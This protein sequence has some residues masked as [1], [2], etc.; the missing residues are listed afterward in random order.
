MEII[1]QKHY[2]KEI[3]KIAEDCI[4][5]RK[6]QVK[7]SLNDIRCNANSLDDII[8]DIVDNHE[9]IT[10]TSYHN[11]VLSFTK[12]LENTQYIDGEDAAFR[13]MYEDVYESVH[14]VLKNG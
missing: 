8:E 10:D 3:K 13:A 5:I 14:E 12:N 4:G 6:G 11:Q 1:T 2:D 9:F 7:L